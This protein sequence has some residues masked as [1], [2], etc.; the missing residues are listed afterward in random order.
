LSE[1]YDAY[2]AFS[3]QDGQGELE[4]SKQENLTPILIRQG[5]LYP[6]GRMMSILIKGT[7]PM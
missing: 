5:N 2:D 6:N 4:E 1:N 7:D 3:I